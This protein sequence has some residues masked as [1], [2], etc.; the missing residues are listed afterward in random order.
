MSL[1]W[2]GP[3]RYALSLDTPGFYLLLLLLGT[4]GLMLILLRRAYPG[5]KRGIEGF[6][7][8]ASIDLGFL[9]SGLV[10]VVALVLAEPHANRTGLALYEVVIGGYWFSFSIPIV[11]VGTSVHRRSRGGV[12]WMVPSLAVA[13]A[14]FVGLF[15]FYFV[16]A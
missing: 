3:G 6:F 13:A 5:R 9:V 10:L 12:P 1:S 8:V 2:P 15:A 14:L 4:F 16:S 11:T 7:E